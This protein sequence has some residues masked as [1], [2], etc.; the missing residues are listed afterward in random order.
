MQLL[1]MING[2]DL[3]TL[4]DSGSTHNFINIAVAQ[5]AGVKWQP[6]VGLHVAVVNGDRLTSLDYR[7][8][9]NIAIGAEPF[10][11]DCYGLEIASYEMVLGVQWLESLRPILWD[12]ERRTMDFVRNDHRVYLTTTGAPS[13]PP[14]VLVKVHLDPRVGFAGLITNN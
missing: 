13:A 3:R 6:T 10:T 1:V 5:C 2:A 14:H 8:G 7:R 11:I 9:L 12:F 4:L